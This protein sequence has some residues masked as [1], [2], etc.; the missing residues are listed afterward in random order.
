MNEQLKKIMIGIVV[1][2]VF[3]ICIALVVV[4]QKNI[5]PAG[6]GT[7][8]IGLGGLIG[9]LWLYNRQYK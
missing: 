1:A 8:L 7:M 6:L 2:I 3:V 9:L 5:G 4:G